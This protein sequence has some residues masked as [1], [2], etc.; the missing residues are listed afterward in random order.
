MRFEAFNAQTQQ[1]NALVWSDSLIIDT[2]TLVSIVHDFN[3]EPDLCVLESA[4][5]TYARY[6]DSYIAMRAYQHIRLNYA[7]QVYTHKNGKTVRIHEALY[8]YLSTLIAYY[9][10]PVSASFCGGIIGYLTYEC[11]TLSHATVPVNPSPGYKAQFMIPRTVIKF[12]NATHEVTLHQWVFKSDWAESIRNCY[13]KT[14]IEVDELKHRLAQPAKAAPASPLTRR[15]QTETLFSDNWTKSEFL[16][17]VETA[18]AYIRAGDIFQMQLSRKRSTALQTSPFYLY[19]LLRHQNPSPFMYYLKLNQTCLLGS[20]PELLV[21]VE[22]T[23]V[24]I[25]PIAGTRKRHSQNKTR[26]DAYIIAELETND[27]E[28]AEH[29]MLVDLARH[30]LKQCCDAGSIRV[31]TLMAIEKYQHVVHMVSDVTGQLSPGYT[32]VDAFKFGFPAGTVTGAPKI[33]A[34]QL[35]HELERE[36]R[37]AYSGGVVFFDF[38]NQLKS[39]LIIRSIFIAGDQATTQAAAGIVADFVPDDEW[40]ETVN[41]MQSSI[42]VMRSVL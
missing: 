9:R 5:P 40:Q 32:A 33:R 27:K 29:V 8:A 20:S 13:E 38:C 30:D 7:D 17:T 24:T 3:T 1:Q 28:R 18:Q 41:K 26:T 12:N 14:K 37:G 35:I 15:I 36:H 31:N 21:G 10:M 23:T 4:D 25:R 34:M 11:V 6:G 16:K 22:A 2:R 39:T 42:D 19:R